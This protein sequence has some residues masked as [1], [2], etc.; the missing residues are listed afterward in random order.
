MIM[1]Y[2]KVYFLCN[3]YNKSLSPFILQTPKSH[4]HGSAC[5]KEVTKVKK[6]KGN[7]AQRVKPLTPSQ[8]TDA[9]IEDEEQK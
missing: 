2:I 1:T 9:L 8:A 4:H 3:L 6:I 5:I 7:E